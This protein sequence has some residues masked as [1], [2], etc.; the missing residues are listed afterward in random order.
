MADYNTERFASNAKANAGLTTGI[1]G[2]SLGG[3]LT[4][5]SGLLGGGGM[6]APRDSSNQYITRY[7]MEIE[8]KLQ[9]ALQK[10]ALLEANIY[11]DR[12][13][14]DVYERLDGKIRANENAIAQQAV[15]NATVNA[16]LACI[17]NQVMQL[18][19]LTKMII[20]ISNIC[21]PPM[22]KYNSWTAPTTATAAAA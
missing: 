13:L 21:P 15:Y 10:N 14:A 16:N 5:A 2:T 11:T 12:K 8:N 9:D 6:V 22:E 17:Q 7:E 19:S 20:P 18:Q 4:L 3:L 1:I